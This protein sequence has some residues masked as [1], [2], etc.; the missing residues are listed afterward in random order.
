[1]LF[2]QK[3]AFSLMLIKRLET[4]FITLIE[5]VFKHIFIDSKKITLP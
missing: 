5:P 2:I 3:D 4:V 1:M